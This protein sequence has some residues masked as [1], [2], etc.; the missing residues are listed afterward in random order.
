MNCKVCGSAHTLPFLERLGVP[1]GQNEVL[2]DERSAKAVVLGDLRMFVCRDCGFVFNAAFDPKKAPYGPTYDNNQLCS[3]VV[4]GY[5]GELVRHIVEDRKVK[6]C[7]VV[8]VGCGS[9]AFIRQLVADPAYGNT[10]IGFD[11]SYQGPDADLDGRLR[12]ERRYYGE[13]ESEYPADVVLCRHVIEHVAEPMQLLDGVRRAL[14][15]AAEPRVFFETPCVE[16]ILRNGVVWDFFYEHCSLFSADSLATAFELNGFNV[17]RVGHLFNG[18]Y[19]L[20]EATLGAS[21]GKRS[22]SGGAVARLAVDY[23]REEPRLLG[24]VEQRIR[25]LAAGSK[26][27][28]WG[29]GAKGVTLANLIDPERKLVDC[30]VDI[31]PN[32]VGAFIPKTGHPIVSYE[33][34][35]SRGV[36]RALLMN[37]NYAGEC[38]DLVAKAGVDVELYV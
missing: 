10:G 2:R 6:G 13:S 19:L 15:S 12:F 37:P 8:E 26:L 25:S 31:N 38:R 18:Q 20:L 35:P 7:R 34:L 21:E 32:K 29:A 23:Q 1:A 22:A 11:P 30:V 24:E 17:D 9:G 33:Q 16:W 36:T 27:A 3:G 5:V 14:K 4:S 28:L